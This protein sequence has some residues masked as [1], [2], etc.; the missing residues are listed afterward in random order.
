[1]KLNFDFKKSAEVLDGVKQKTTELVQKTSET[2]IQVALNV[3]EN[4]QKSANEFSEKSK[5]DSFERRMK[6]YNPL[7]LEVY[8]SDVFLFQILFVL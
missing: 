7:F 6:K 1:M 2:G 5:Q 3:A 8:K 4:I